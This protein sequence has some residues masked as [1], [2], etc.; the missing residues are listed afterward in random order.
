L[1]G[2]ALVC[3]SGLGLADRIICM[4]LHDPAIKDRIIPALGRIGQTLLQ[5]VVPIFHYEGANQY[6]GAKIDQVGCGF[7]AAGGSNYF[8]VTA[9]HVLR[10]QIA[11][12]QLY[13]PLGGNRIR[14]IYGRY[15]LTCLLHTNIKSSPPVLSLA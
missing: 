15:L 8:L 11:N 13:F 14:K 10:N 2:D 5:C 3:G 12:G 1:G 9:A 6:G 4:D 7:L